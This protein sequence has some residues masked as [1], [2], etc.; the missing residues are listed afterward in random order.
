MGGANLHT[1]Q[2]VF[3]HM[4]G[5]QNSPQQGGPWLQMP[6]VPTLSMPWSIPALQQ[7]DLI[8]FTGERSQPAYGVTTLHHKRKLNTPDIADTR[9]VKQFITEEKMASHFQGLHISSNYQEQNSSTST[10]I[11]GVSQSGCDN[12]QYTSTS[13]EN[14]AQTVDVDQNDGKQP[15]LVISEELRQMQ[16]EPLIPVTLLSKLERP[17]MALVLWEPPR[18]HLVRVPPRTRDMLTPILNSNENGSTN[19]SNNDNNNNTNNNNNGNNNNNN[20]ID[21]LN[22]CSAHL[23]PMEL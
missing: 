23:E 21:D 18:K 10:S 5:Q 3:Q 15:R 2:S 14:T 11:V 1:P 17:S 8:R 9:Q 16:E 12:T 13:M 7:P 19:N 20:N 22:H 6:Q 4:M